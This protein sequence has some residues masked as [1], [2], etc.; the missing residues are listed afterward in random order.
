M[1]MTL[2]VLPDPWYTFSIA[3]NVD[4][5]KPGIYCWLID[6]VESYIGKYSDI[7]RPTQHYGRIVKRKFAGGAY[8]KSNPNGFRR[9]HI[10]LCCA[11]QEKREIELRILENVEPARLQERETELIRQLRPALNGSAVAI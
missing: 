9:V 5:S 11:V 1:S 4:R 8:R 7:T 3:E 10:A 6:G 2:C